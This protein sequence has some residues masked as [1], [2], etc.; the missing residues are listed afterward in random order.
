M[1]LLRISP[2]RP[3]LPARRSRLIHSIGRLSDQSGKKTPPRA[4]K[5]LFQPRHPGCLHDDIVSES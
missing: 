3:H 5:D 2:A 1:E 4:A